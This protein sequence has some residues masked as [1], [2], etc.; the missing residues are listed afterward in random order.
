MVLLGQ[1]RSKQSTS[2]RDIQTPCDVFLTKVF[3][4]FK[5]EIL[6]KGPHFE[7]VLVIEKNFASVEVEQGS[8]KVIW[9]VIWKS[10][11][12]G[13][14]ARKDSPFEE[15]CSLASLNKSIKTRVYV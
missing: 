1:G 15:C 13:R 11:G 3:Q 6:A 5:V 4:L 14:R 8:P 2:I 7:Y 12:L 10:D 9:F